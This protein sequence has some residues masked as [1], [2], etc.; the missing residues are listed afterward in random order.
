MKIYIFKIIKNKRLYKI[1]LEK[2]DGI[3][4]KQMVLELCDD[5]HGSIDS[6]EMEEYTLNKVIR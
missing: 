4:A 5:I 3:K 2:P 6:M 1:A